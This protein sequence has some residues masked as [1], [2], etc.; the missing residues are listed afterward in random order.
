MTFVDIPFHVIDTSLKFFLYLANTKKL[1]Y[2]LISEAKIFLKTFTETE[3]IDTFDD[4]NP[5]TTLVKEQFGNLIYIERK[6]NY[7]GTDLSL[8]KKLF[9]IIMYLFHV[10]LKVSVALLMESIFFKRVS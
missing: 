7:P 2:L 6:Y 8:N 10:K 4:L 3:I 9:S 1:S 5:L